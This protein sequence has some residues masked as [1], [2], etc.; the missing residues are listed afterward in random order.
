MKARFGFVSN[1]SSSAFVVAFPTVP[2]DKWELLRMM[3]PNGETMI[4]AYGDPVATASVADT[5]W[6]DM[7]NQ[8]P[9]TFDEIAE[10]ISTGEFSGNPDYYY[11]YVSWDKDMTRK[12]RQAAWAKYEEAS[13]EAAKRL[14]EVFVGA[15]TGS[16]FFRFSY[17]D[18]N[19][20]YY[21]TLEHGEIF[22]NLGHLQISHH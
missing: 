13:Q 22:R 9:M 1:S 20:P 10:E 3:F 19:G 17:A 21:C 6:N 12:E 7:K 8:K 18:G 2:K 11:D 5:V 14:A 4:E 15:N 16:T